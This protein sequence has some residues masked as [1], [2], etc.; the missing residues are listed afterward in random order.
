MGKI[1]RNENRK[2]MLKKMDA[3][4]TGKSDPNISSEDGGPAQKRKTWQPA[5]EKKGWENQ[6]N[7]VRK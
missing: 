3:L 2:K 4:K 5:A 1:R 6:K 7:R